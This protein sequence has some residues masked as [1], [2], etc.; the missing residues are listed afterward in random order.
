MCEKVRFSQIQSHL[1][2]YLFIYFIYSTIYLFT[3]YYYLLYLN[4]IYTFNAHTYHWGSYKSYRSIIAH[5]H[6]DM[7]RYNL[8]S[9]VSFFAGIIIL[10]DLGLMGLR[11]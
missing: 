8:C 4:H 9:C 3:T 6:Y 7:T 5:I 11:F 2:I 1:Y 10:I